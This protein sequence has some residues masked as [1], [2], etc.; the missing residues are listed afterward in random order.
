MVQKTEFYAKFWGVRGSIACP[1]AETIRYGGNTACLEV[2]CGDHTLIFDAGTGVRQLGNKIAKQESI[3]LDI[4]LSHTHFDHVCGLPFFAPFFSPGNRIR[5]HAGHLGSEYKLREVLIEMMMAP[6]FPVPPSIFKADV[7]W[8]DFRAGETLQPHSGITLSTAPLNHPNNA[9]GYRVD[10]EGRSVCYITDYEH[11][12]GRRDEV[13]IGLVKGADYMIYDSTYSDE[14]Y[15]QFR[16]FGHSTW[17]QGLRVAEEAEVGKLVIFH[18]DPDHDDRWMDNVANK[19]EKLRPGT[20]V[21]KEG[22]VLSP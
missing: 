21:A 16:G 5:V 20:I 13:L 8:S 6:L 14:E 10:F 2:K 15:E 17:Q 12:E 1:G 4:F 3:D 9:T 11:L 18:H 7:T 19:A 22:M